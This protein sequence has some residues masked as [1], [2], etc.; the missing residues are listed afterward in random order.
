MPKTIENHVLILHV[1]LICCKKE[2]DYSHVKVKT[3]ITIIKTTKYLSPSYIFYWPLNV[4]KWCET[5]SKSCQEYISLKIS[6]IRPWTHPMSQ[7]FKEVLSPAQQQSRD[8][9]KMSKKLF[10]HK[11]AKIRL[12]L[13][14]ISVKRIKIWWKSQND[15]NQ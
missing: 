7:F 1:A 3:Q 14:H 11:L 9:N 13:S 6:I 12:F 5:M 10:F 8:A 15:G 4:E 2:A